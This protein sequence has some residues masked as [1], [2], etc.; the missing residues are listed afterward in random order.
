MANK[1]S[2]L[3]HNDVL[4]GILFNTPCLRDTQLGI[5]FSSLKKYASILIFLKTYDNLGIPFALLIFNR[6]I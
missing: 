5:F 3:F 1:A 2:E 4:S 6:H